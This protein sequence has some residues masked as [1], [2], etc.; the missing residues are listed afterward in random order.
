MR[1]GRLDGGLTGAP[2]GPSTTQQVT[3]AK[4]APGA[5]AGPSSAGPVLKPH[6][7]TSDGAPYGKRIYNRPN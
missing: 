5:R 1:H 2:G 3:P 7:N 4:S 6:T